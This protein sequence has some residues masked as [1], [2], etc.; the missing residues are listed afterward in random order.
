[1]LDFFEQMLV[2]AF[3]LP[4]IKKCLV[5][6]HNKFENDLKTTLSRTKLCLLASLVRL[7]RERNWVGMGLLCLDVL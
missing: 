5:H 4:Q 7:C 1:M 6:K 3:F 2:A